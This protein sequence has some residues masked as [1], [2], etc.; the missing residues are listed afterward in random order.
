M[1]GAIREVKFHGRDLTDE[2]RRRI[3]V[4]LEEDDVALRER[5][6][7]VIG[8]LRL[9]LADSRPGDVHP[10][11]AAAVVA[12]TTA[13]AGGAAG[14]L[15]VPA[16]VAEYGWALNRTRAKLEKI[17]T[18]MERGYVV[19]YWA[20]GEPNPRDGDVEDGSRRGFCYPSLHYAARQINVTQARF[21]R[22]HWD[23]PQDLDDAAKDQVLT[24]KR[25]GTLL[26]ELSHLVWDTDDYDLVYDTTFHED[27]WSAKWRFLDDAYWYGGFHQTDDGRRDFATS[28]EF[29]IGDVARPEYLGWLVERGPEWNA[30]R[31]DA[32]TNE[33]LGEP[34]W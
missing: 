15:R 32:K 1:M 26:H 7:A 14:D 2:D 17:L 30:E 27:N 20:Y 16:F 11:N 34:Y 22:G 33:W 23:V 8:E 5:L 24:A 31:P 10:Y 19:G 21:D 6:R 29:L 3:G 4:A 13:F 18:E 9:A 25:R 28:I 12:R